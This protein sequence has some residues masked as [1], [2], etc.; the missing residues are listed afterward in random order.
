MMGL[1]QAIAGEFP[2]EPAQARKHSLLIAEDR[3]LLGLLS[4]VKQYSTES[5]Y[6][7][8]GFTETPPFQAM[9]ARFIFTEAPDEAIGALPLLEDWQ[10]PN[11]LAFDE[12]KPGYF[13]G[14]VIELAENCLTNGLNIEHF[15]LFGSKA[16][17]DK[18]QQTLSI[19][20]SYT[21]VIE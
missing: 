18:T 19:Q 16:F 3:G 20:A 17:I 10:L 2:I 9:P 12:F 1:E 11:R 14:S 5:S 6:A 13:E 15:C 4:Y 8:L 7:L 21:Q